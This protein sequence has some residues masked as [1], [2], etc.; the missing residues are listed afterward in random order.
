[1]NFENKSVCSMQFRSIYCHKTAFYNHGTCI[2][3]QMQNY[4][5]RNVVFAYYL[6]NFCVTCM[7]KFHFTQHVFYILMDPKNEFL[8]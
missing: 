7:P 1:M 5:F 2:M 6:F 3:S 4:D 8:Y